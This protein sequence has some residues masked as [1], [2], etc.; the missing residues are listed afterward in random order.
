M[1][2]RI[3]VKIVLTQYSNIEQIP[4]L[5]TIPYCK[6]VPLFLVSDWKLLKEKG[7]MFR[8]NTVLKQVDI[9]ANGK[10][11]IL[12]RLL[13]FFFQI[14]LFFPTIFIMEITY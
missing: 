13:S 4:W 3:N 6:K 10:Q 14:V 11:T 5:I 2:F 1:V 9:L 12:K 7:N 8:D